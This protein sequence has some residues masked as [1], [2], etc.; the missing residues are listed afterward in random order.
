LLL[1]NAIKRTLL[2]R[3]T[4]GIY[5]V[6]VEAKDATAEAFYRRYGFRPCDALTRQLYLPLGRE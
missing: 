5:A 2:A 6:V 4:L 3:H 1:P